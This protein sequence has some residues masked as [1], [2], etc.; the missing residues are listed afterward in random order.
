[1]TADRMERSLVC[2]ECGATTTDGRGWR[3]LP[4]VGDEAA[5]DEDQMA[6]FCPECMER[7]FSE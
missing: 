6:I 2:A 4:T 5:E 3:A 7:E 1:M